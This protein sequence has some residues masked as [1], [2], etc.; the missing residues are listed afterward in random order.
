MEKSAKR[1]GMETKNLLMEGPICNDRYSL[2]QISINFDKNS[3]I[4]ISIINEARGLKRTYQNVDKNPIQIALEFTNAEL[5]T[6][7]KLI[8]EMKEKVTNKHLN[9]KQ[10]SDKIDALFLAFQKINLLRK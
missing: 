8:D 2:M 6:A 10:I 7:T 4:N 1:K 9:K 5:D 3:N